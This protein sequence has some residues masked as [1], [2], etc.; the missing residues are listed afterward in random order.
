MKSKIRWALW[1]VLVSLCLGAC[2]G[3]AD[4]AAE[5]A[6]IGTEAPSETAPETLWDQAGETTE[7]A[8]GETAEEL[9]AE[10]EVPVL[11]SLMKN[12][13]YDQV[14]D[15][16]ELLCHTRYSRIWLD[17]REEADPETGARAFPQLAKALEELNDQAAAEAADSIEELETKARDM[18]ADGYSRELSWEGEVWVVRADSQVTSL[19]RQSSSYLGGAHGIYGYGASVFDSRTGR[20]LSLEEAVTDTDRL[21]ELAQKRLQEKYGEEQFWESAKDVVKEEA[22]DGSLTWTAGYEGLTIYFDPYELAPYSY[23]ALTAT[24]LYEEEPDLFS[25]KIR[26]VPDSWAVQV[27]PGLEFDLG[28]DKV[29]DTVEV[30]GIS[31]MDSGY[32]KLRVSVKGQESLTDMWFYDYTSYVVHGSDLD[33]ELLLVETTSDNDYEMIWVYELDPEREGFQTPWQFPAT[34]FFS[35][36]QEEENGGGEY[37]TQVFTDPKHFCLQTHIDL[38]STYYGNRWYKIMADCRTDGYVTP[39]QSWYDV[40]RG[41]YPLTLLV[42]LEME[43]E[44]TG[45]LREF[46]AGTRLWIVRVEDSYVGFVTEDGTRCRVWVEP[47]WPGTVRGRE[48]LNAEDI[49][50]GMMFAG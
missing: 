11:L 12:S 36:Y 13:Q 42:P 46:P 34:G 50:D 2:A 44:G 18:A 28:Q 48:D 33:T 41:D 31:Y 27:I 29:L 10:E 9:P 45:E 17:S 32:E 8:A 30:G 3:P 24:I 5:P 14:W 1:P 7:E 26:N 16:G 37:G 21:G 15:E 47:G 23:G 25:E 39:E 35:Y 20:R 40:D 43:L 19:L 6:E 49:F 22:E 38:L 4:K